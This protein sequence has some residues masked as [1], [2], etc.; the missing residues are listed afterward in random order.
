MMRC[1]SLVIITA[2][3]HI[4]RN[5]AEER[6]GQTFVHTIFLIRIITCYL[7][8]GMPGVCVARLG[9]ELNLI[10][11]GRLNDSQRNVN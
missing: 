8:V 9:G 10:A 6:G 5:P 4:G 1:K 11:G 3:P 7:L 2:G